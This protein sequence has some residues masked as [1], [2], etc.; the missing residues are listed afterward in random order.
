MCVGFG[1]TFFYP[2]RRS[3]RPQKSILNSLC[4]YFHA[5]NR[6]I[7]FRKTGSFY[8]VHGEKGLV[9]S[10]KRFVNIASANQNCWSDNFNC[11]NNSINCHTTITV[12]AA[13]S[14][15]VTSTILVSWGYIKKTFCRGN[16]IIFSV[17]VPILLPLPIGTLPMLTFNS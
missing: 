3:G 2:S 5:K 6:K 9:A 7:W 8:C 14:K 15:I 13:T 11:Y 12:V 16:K 1:A 4:F 10:A 17:M